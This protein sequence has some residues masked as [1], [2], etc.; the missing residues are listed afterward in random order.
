MS[1]EFSPTQVRN[2]L[3]AHI[4][5]L[6]FAQD[7]ILRKDA[8]ALLLGVERD[9]AF[10]GWP[11][12]EAFDLSRFKLGQELEALYRYAF[13]GELVGEI[14]DESEEGNLGWLIALQGLLATPSVEHY[15]EEIRDQFDGA[16]DDQ[17][18]RGL[19]ELA[20][21]AAARCAVDHGDR[22]TLPQLA[23]L[24]DMEER[25]V[26]NA[27]H[28][29]G[30]GG[31]VAGRSPEGEIFVEN[32]EANRWL[33][34]RRGY[35]KTVRLGTADHPAYGDPV[36]ENL[37]PEDVVPFIRQ[38]LAELYRENRT[39]PDLPAF[40]S[41]RALVDATP[42][43]PFGIN[44][45]VAA[46]RLNWP[47]ERLDRVLDV[48]LEALSPED[49]PALSRAMYVDGR[50][51]I[52]QVMRAKFP[53][54]MSALAPATGAPAIQRSALDIQGQTLD[55]PLTAA[56]I[57]NGYVDLERRFADQLFPADAFGSR[58]GDQ[59][60]VSVELHHDQP[61]SPWISDL[62]VKSAALV[63][64]RKRFSAYFSAHRAEPGDVVRFRRIGERS[65]Q[66]EFLPKAK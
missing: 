10:S 22:L 32:A 3:V 14:N 62:R 49:C 2:D 42:A 58:S 28:A 5:A 63:S 27:L 46:S 34:G 9:T 16:G 8:S 36:P 43:D 30:S 41:L 60:G 55:A 66:I 57:R 18:A 33:E 24:A 11:C 61:H 17:K 35:R 44:R 37:A 6:A 26:R 39:Y 4:Y 12:Y 7:Q 52:A 47:R 51:L 15:L 64:P 25:S 50:W 29:K 40:D 1:Q 21:R 13:A 48:G 38:R 53:K 65:Y 56:G 54:A 20:R 19:A 31:L 45:H 23:L 59:H